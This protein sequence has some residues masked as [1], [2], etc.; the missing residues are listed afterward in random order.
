[1]NTL[2]IYLTISGVAEKANIQKKDLKLNQK[3]EKQAAAA[4]PS[5][6]F[7]AFNQFNV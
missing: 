1:M 6:P 5:S 4:F 3:Q 2:A 7:N